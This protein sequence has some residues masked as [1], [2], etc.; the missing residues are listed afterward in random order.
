MYATRI[1]RVPTAIGVLLLCSAC[2]N[3][4]TPHVPPQTHAI[5]ID[6]TAEHL[7]AGSEMPMYTYHVP[8]SQVLVSGHPGGGTS[9]TAVNGIV[10]V[11]GD[12]RGA[13]RDKM[14]VKPFE[15]ALHISLASLAPQE[16]STLLVSAPFSQKF[17]LEPDASAPT[18]SISGDVVLMF[19]TDSLVRPYVILN[20]KLTPPLGRGLSWT[21]RY[22]ASR[23]AARSLTGP[24]GWASDRGTLLK[25][26]VAADLQRVLAVM[27]QDVSS[28][29][30]RDRSSKFTVQGHFPFM[31]HRLQLVGYVL[32]EDAGAIYFLPNMPSTSLL[33]TVYI[34]DKSA[35]T[36]RAA[37][38]DDRRIKIAAEQ[39]EGDR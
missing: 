36:I 11:S 14:A 32:G 8:S 6:F 35:I 4:D 29:F 19:E 25:A 27:L 24:D 2:I 30:V 12:S 31:E 26:T 13:F 38:S 10:G 1:V 20:A 33:A 16:L 34:M 17:T 21:M 23:G 37:T 5:V 15:E 28:P 7:S 3:L 18:L 9:I 22:A 39:N